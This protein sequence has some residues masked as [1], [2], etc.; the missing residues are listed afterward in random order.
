MSFNQDCS[1]ITVIIPTTAEKSRKDTLLLAIESLVNQIE[2]TPNILIVINGVLYDPDLK[3]KLE[4]T[5]YLKVL[6]QI[7]GSAPKACAFGRKQITSKFFCFLDDDDY[8]LP[9]AIK[10][11]IDIFKENESIDVV[12]SNGLR[13]LPNKPVTPIFQEGMIQA[14][15]DPL[16]CLFTKKSNWMA[17]CAATFR[18]ATISSS[19]FDSHTEFYEWTYLAIRISLKMKLFFIDEPGY[20]INATSNSLSTTPAFLIG[21]IEFHKAVSSLDLPKE[22]RKRSIIRW[23]DSWHSLS[24]HYRRNGNYLLAWKAHFHS[25][26]TI[27]GFIKYILHSRK[28]LVNNKK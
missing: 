2:V 3:I 11:R 6:Y 24:E 4:N 28:L 10:A 9:D 17:S 16:K 26:S 14:R 25:L 18:T 1:D 5:S 7:T 19:F 13:K 8:L 22:I 20:V 27:S 15:K 21:Q 12:I 23:V